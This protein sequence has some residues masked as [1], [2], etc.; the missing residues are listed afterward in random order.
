MSVRWIRTAK[1]KGGKFMEAIGWAKEMAAFAPKKFGAPEVN[2]YL[3]TVGN[4]GSIRWIVDY[5]D[6]AAFEK[7]T[8]QVLADKEYWQIVNKAMS[9]GLFVDGETH[10][11][12]L[13][14]L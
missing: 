14:K 3:D 12:I 8:N 2:V 10:D 11:T 5:D 9:D 1:I 6:M 4:V 7:V 13:K